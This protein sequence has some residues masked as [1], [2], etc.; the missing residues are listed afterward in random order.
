MIHWRVKG[1]VTGRTL[2]RFLALLKPY[3][4]LLVQAC[5]CLIILSVCSIAV[6]W[7]LTIVIDHAVPGKNLMLAIAI[8]AGLLILNFFTQLFNYLSDYLIRYVANKQVFDLRR[9]LFRHIQRLSLRFYDEHKTGEI[10]SRITSDVSSFQNMLTG[11]TLSLI[12]NSI[13]FVGILALMFWMH[14]ILTLLALSVFPFHVLIYLVYH[15]RVWS[16]SKKQ[17]DKWADIHSSATEVLG[18]ARLVKSFTS[19]GRESR[20]FVQEIRKDF[21][22]RFD[23]GTVSTQ[24]DRLSNFFFGLGRVVVLGFGAKVMIDGEMTIGRFVA[25]YSYN[26]M[27]YQPVMQLVQ[28][29]THIV[30]ALTGLERVYEYLDVEPDV[31]EAPDAIALHNIKGEVE[32]RN[33]RFSYYEGVEVL[34]GINFHAAPGEVIALVG[35]SGAGKS[36]IANLIA[37]FYDV[38]AG[39]V[40]IDGTDIRKLKLRTYREQV[41]MV[42]QDSILFS[43][44]I[45][46][47]IRYGNPDALSKEIEEAAH[48]ANAHHFI[49]GFPDGYMTEAGEHGAKL[50]GGQ[51]QRIAIARAI[52]RNPRI[53]ILDEA[54]SSLDTASELLIQEAL[55]RLMRGRTTF[56]IAHRLSTIKKANKILVIRE[57]RIEQVGTHEELLSKEGLYRTLYEPELVRKADIAKLDLLQVA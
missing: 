33:V 3:T 13:M 8:V 2:R 6:P 16:V 44:T 57:G 21:D 25:F 4:W 42:L 34:H 52:L 54:T 11:N 18:A 38:K 39:D 17:R 28:I 56:I 12:T 40:L 43:G 26:V 22:L 41:A 50:S 10:L 30:P 32:F 51:R 49:V 14:P 29:I 19:E 7:G 47:N 53:L 20:R 37:R 36:T 46:D 48:M 27:L 15:D 35:P 9:Q 45:E 1:K 23:M 31:K 24:W 55:D 5:T